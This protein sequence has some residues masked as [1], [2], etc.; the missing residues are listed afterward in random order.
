M[1]C[2]KYSEK[3]EEN[4][5]V[6]LK[7]LMTILVVL[8][9]SCI[10]YTGIG[11]GGFYPIKSN[12]LLGEVAEWLNSFHIY[13]FTF[14]SGYFFHFSR[15]RR[16][17]KQNLGKSLIHRAKKLMIPYFF[18]CFAWVLPIAY[19]VLHQNVTVKNVFFEIV[20]AQNPRQLWYLVMIFE[21]YIVFEFFF[22]YIDKADWKMVVFFNV[23]FYYS[24]FFWPNIFPFNSFQLSSLSG[25]FL[26]Y[27]FGYRASKENAIKKTKTNNIMLFLAVNILSWSVYKYCSLHVEKMLK[28]IALLIYPLINLEGIVTGI[29]ISKYLMIKFPIIT[30]KTIEKILPSSMGIYILH[31]QIVYIVLKKILNKGFSPLFVSGIA[32]VASITVSY[33]IT[34]FIRK[35]KFGR[36]VL[37]G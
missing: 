8:Y 31:Q 14:A 19:Y 10:V 35:L 21:C 24:H 25:H 27:Y 3:N 36:F 22:K 2:L 15:S 1:N 34:R 23:L 20:L 16:K 4:I 18:F 11:W 12:Y 28:M 17:E 5:I 6:L 13:C 29:K 32:F 37:G 7:C 26:M 9:H 33:Y 30:N